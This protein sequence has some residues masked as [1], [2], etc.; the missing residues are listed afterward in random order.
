MKNHPSE[1]PCRYRYTPY[2]TAETRRVSATS[3]QYSREAFFLPRTRPPYPMYQLVTCRSTIIPSMR[4]GAWSTATTHSKHSSTNQRY[5]S[6][7]DGRCELMP[8]RIRILTIRIPVPKK[9]SHCSPG[10]RKATMKDAKNTVNPMTAS[11]CI[12][13]TVSTLLSAP[14][15]RTTLMD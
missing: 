5:H 15:M 7:R 8:K 11:R 2:P 12:H 13:L 4:P 9:G 3:I 14:S 1:V 10:D 6:A